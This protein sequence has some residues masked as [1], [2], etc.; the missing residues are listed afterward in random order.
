ME[1]V[2]HDD[3]G[4]KQIRI[5]SVVFK[6]LLHQYCP[7]LVAKERLPINSLGADKE[8]MPVA[9]DCFSCRT[10]HGCPQWL[11]PHGLVV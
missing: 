4:V 10:T 1:V 2:R 5:A 3:V 7:S 9:P 6:N 11:K 8:R